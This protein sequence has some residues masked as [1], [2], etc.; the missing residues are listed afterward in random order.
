MT[1]ACPTRYS[2]KVATITHIQL[3]SCARGIVNSLVLGSCNN[4]VHGIALVVHVDVV[5][6]SD[7]CSCASAC[8]DLLV[9][10]CPCFASYHDSRNR[11]VV[12]FVCSSTLC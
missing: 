12:Q 5:V 10:V 8:R 3:F 4:N 7:V 2:D 1:K 6:F 11:C 9:F